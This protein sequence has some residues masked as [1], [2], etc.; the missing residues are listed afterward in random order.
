MSVL[1]ALQNRKSVRAFL[2]KPVKRDVIDQILLAARHAPSGVNMQPWLVSVVSGEKK[3]E[4]DEKLTACFDA[5]E[6]EVLDYQYYPLQWIEPFRSR[7]K[8]TGLLMYQTLQI[9]RRDVEKQK[10]QWRQNFLAF[11]APTV[12]YVTLDEG[13]EAGS[14]MDAGMFIQSI[15]LAATEL[16][17]ATCPQAA[18]AGYPGVVK[19]A[20]NIPKEKVLLCGIALGYEDTSAVINSYRTPRLELSEFVSYF[21]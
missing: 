13:L 10:H 16:G 9:E 19:Q 15:M 5:G 4:L 17:L 12:L 1:D 11:G 18:L 2:D 14:Y 8:E 3:R 6:K 21:D 20:L 7:R